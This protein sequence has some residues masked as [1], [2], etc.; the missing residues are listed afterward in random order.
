MDLKRIV[1][2]LRTT[3]WQLDRAFPRATL[4][5]IE[6]A[7]AA[8]EKLHTGEIRFVVEA[9]LDAGPLFKGLSARERALE[10]FAHLRIWDTAQ[11]NGVLIY[12]LLAD[13]DVEIIADRGIHAITGTTQWEAICHA[14]ESAFRQGDYKTG[15]IQGIETV[16]GYLV[17]HFPG[18]GN[19]G[20]YE[21]PDAP[22]VL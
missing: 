9:A 14:M 21:L 4:T 1:R 3:H 19:V 15:V 16:S 7:I 10:L 20:E 11:N 13:R 18:V 6:H 17:K 12:L 2:H 8:G 22:L 5:A